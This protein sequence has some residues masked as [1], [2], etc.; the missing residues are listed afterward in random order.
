MSP[1]RYETWG[2][3]NADA[4]NAVLVQHA[5]TGSTHVARGATDEDGWWE[6]LVGPGEPVDTDRYF[7]VAANM[8]GGCY[9]TTGPSS[10]AARRQ[11]LGSQVSLHHYPGLGTGGGAAGGPAGHPRVVCR[12]GRF[13]GRRAGT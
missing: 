7:V 4:S 9:G 8:L 3:L 10:I 1:S 5:L 6:G 13:H 12:V 11:A 2:T